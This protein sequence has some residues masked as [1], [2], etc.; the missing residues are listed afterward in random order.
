MRRSEELQA[1]IAFARFEDF[2]DELSASRADWLLDSAVSEFARDFRLSR[3]S[4][5]ASGCRDAAKFHETNPLRSKIHGIEQKKLDFVFE[6]ARGCQ[7]MVLQLV[8]DPLDCLQDGHLRLTQNFPPIFSCKSSSTRSCGQGPCGTSCT[9]WLSVCQCQYSGIRVRRGS[10]YRRRSRSG[11]RSRGT[12]CTWRSG[13]V[14]RTSAYRSFLQLLQHSCAPY[15]SVFSSPL[16]SSTRVRL[17]T[18]L[19]PL[20]ETVVGLVKLLPGGNVVLAVE[21]RKVGHAVRRVSC[22]APVL[23]SRR[24]G[25]RVG[26][27]NRVGNRV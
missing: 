17:S 1:D 3:G 22:D 24:C 12:A 20:P 25:R 5:V 19:L 9:W 27:A 26:A 16:C 21:T 11:W 6:C 18:H 8:F 15:L 4:S 10:T 23:R 2:A 14:V 13:P 7:G